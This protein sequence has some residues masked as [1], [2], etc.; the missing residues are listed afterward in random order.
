M[1]LFRRKLDTADKIQLA[2]AYSVRVLVAA[3]AVEAALE[4]LW[5]I[6]FT[7]LLILA[8]TFFPSLLERRYR[9]FFPTEVELAVVVFIY[10]ALFLGEIKGY[11]TKIWW[12]D[13]MLHAGSGVAFGF[14]GFLVLYML[15][16]K[17][18]LTSSP[19]WMAFFSFCFAVAIG[20]LWEIFEFSMDRAFGFNMQKSGLNDTMGD[21]IVDSVGAFATATI[22]F[23]YLKGKKEGLINRVITRFV[24][25][26]PALFKPQR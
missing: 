20:A 24:A 11:Y 26:N 2:L 17:N 5:L 12:W 4:G 16:R 23:Y 14:A 25:Q 3:A 7:S 15:Y 22:G 8:L 1:Q 13:I 19:F 9:L 6:L 21:L 18:A 10:F